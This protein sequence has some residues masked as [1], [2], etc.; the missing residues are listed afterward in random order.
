[1]PFTLFEKYEYL[2]YKI[3][4]LKNS[5]SLEEEENF[6]NIVLNLIHCYETLLIA[7]KERFYAPATQIMNETMYFN[8][9]GKVRIN[10]LLVSIEFE[11]E[12][13]D[14]ILHSEEND[15]NQEKIIFLNNVKDEFNIIINLI[16]SF[17][18]NYSEENTIKLLNDIYFLVNFLHDKFVF[19]DFI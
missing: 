6:S 16:N 12:V 8:E 13:N 3:E 14:F 15:D 5:D 4:E 7:I 10:F 17:Y 11:N 9:C 18:N 19:Y 2:Y 1:M